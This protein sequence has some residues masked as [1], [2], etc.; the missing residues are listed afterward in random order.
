MKA[1]C[2]GGGGFKHRAKFGA[3][4]P[5]C[6]PAKRRLGRHYCLPTAAEITTSVAAG[7]PSH[8]CIHWANGVQCTS[9]GGLVAVGHA[10]AGR[11]VLE[12]RGGEVVYQKWP[13]SI[14]LL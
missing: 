5:T 2:K 8:S 1:E 3:F 12:W 9:L 11:D 13:K 4:L 10:G 14:F 7:H 6:F